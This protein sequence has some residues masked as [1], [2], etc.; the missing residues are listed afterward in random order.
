M[1]SPSAHNPEQPEEGREVPELLPVEDL[2]AE[3]LRA[4]SSI[5]AEREILPLFDE[6]CGAVGSEAN[7]TSQDVA[8]E[9][10][11]RAA[12]L[13]YLGTD[14]RTSSEFHARNLAA[15]R[16]AQWEGS[17]AVL[18]AHEVF[19]SDSGRSVIP[20]E[21]VRPDDAGYVLPAFW[22]SRS[23]ESFA[24]P[25]GIIGKIIP[26]SNLTELEPVFSS[27]AL[28]EAKQSLRAIAVHIDRLIRQGE[29]AYIS[30]LGPGSVLAAIMLNAIQFSHERGDDG[31]EVVWNHDGPAPV[32]RDPRLE[33]LLGLTRLRLDVDRANHHEVGVAAV[34]F[35]QHAAGI[36]RAMQDPM[37]VGSLLEKIYRVQVVPEGAFVPEAKVVAVQIKPL[38]TA[39]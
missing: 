37:A 11:L 14:E 25:A 6:Y 20:L 21:I 36:L 22:K 15:R 26:D 12:L 10:L 9:R 2:S 5:D 19:A 1:P 29:A 39:A 24:R 17:P 33:P 38:R 18:F 28:T 34:N 3:D 35:S 23:G 13:E 30:D 16:V 31:V 8:L 32:A 4:H 27:A 7:L